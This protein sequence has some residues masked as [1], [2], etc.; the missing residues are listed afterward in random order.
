MPHRSQPEDRRQNRPDA[1]GPSKCERTADHERRRAA[2]VVDAQLHPGVA[3]ERWNRRQP[4]DVE[5]END[6]HHAHDLG[7]PELETQDRDTPRA[8]DVTHGHRPDPERFCQTS[9]RG[10]SGRE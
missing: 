3:I 8:D 10:R 5:A 1:R 9:Y 6:N 2:V 7:E 4:C